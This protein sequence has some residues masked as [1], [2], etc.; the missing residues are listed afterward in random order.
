MLGFPT[1]PKVSL[2]LIRNQQEAERKDKSAQG[3]K[4]ARKPIATP[5]R[6]QP[7]GCKMLK[8]F[9]YFR[10][11]CFGIHCPVMGRIICF[12]FLSCSSSCCVENHR[13]ENHQKGHWR[14]KKQS[15]NAA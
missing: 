5:G 6:F 3:K 9:H 15:N 14:T 4:A 7:K 13:H 12:P 11:A 8:C 1:S 2:R 10:R